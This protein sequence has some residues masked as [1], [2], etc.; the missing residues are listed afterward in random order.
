MITALLL[1]DDFTDDEGYQIVTPAQRTLLIPPELRYIAKA[2]NE[3][4]TVVNGSS[5]LEVN[6]A[7]GFADN[8]VV[9]MFFTDPTDWFLLSDPK[10]PLSPIAYI[11]LNGNTTPFIGLKDPGVRAV[12]GGND[13]YSF[14]FDEVKYK[15]RHDFHFKPIEWRGIIGSQN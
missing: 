11:T 7:R 3:N 6:T 4:E 1:F 9:E 10:G 13:P 14:D 12:L 8:I 15:L 2:L 5:Q